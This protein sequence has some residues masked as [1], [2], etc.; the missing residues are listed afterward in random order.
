M[1]RRLSIT[2]LALAIVG[3]GVAT[4]RCITKLC[5][6]AMA[7]QMDCCDDGE[8]VSAPDCCPQGTQVSRHSASPLADSPARLVIAAATQM[9][10]VAVTVTAP[11]LPL[12]LQVVEP[13]AAPP[14][15]SLIAQHTSLLL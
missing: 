7:K 6:V 3:G 14:G 8:G 5:A 9:V 1:L 15:G 11:E 10:A 4:C 2:L 13:E 12:V